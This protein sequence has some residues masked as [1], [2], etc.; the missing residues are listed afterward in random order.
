MPALRVLPA[1]P[2]DGGASDAKIGA[3]SCHRQSLSQVSYWAAIVYNTDTA[4]DRD[5]DRVLI[6]QLVRR[7]INDRRLPLGRSVG[8]RET[9]GDGRPC[10]ACGERIS[11][12]EKLILAMVSLEATSV[13]FHVD[14]YNVWDIE[15][16]AVFKEKGGGDARDQ[17]ARQPL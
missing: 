9:S 10:D 15:R 4:T 11:Q 12:A 2:R 3:S 16:R 17:S 8:I 7:R 5:M 6:Q 14:C 1:H 13:R